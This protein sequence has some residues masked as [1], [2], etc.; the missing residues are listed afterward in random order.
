MWKCELGQF[1]EETFSLC[2]VGG[3]AR[4][5]WLTSIWGWT[6]SLFYGNT[7]H[8]KTHSG[9]KSNKCNQYDYTSSQVSHLRTHL[10]N[11]EWTKVEQMQPVWLCIHSSRQFEDTFEKTQLLQRKIYQ[12]DAFH[13]I[14]YILQGHPERMRKVN[15]TAGVLLFKNL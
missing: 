3:S 5:M 7:K 6:L 12:A 8:L 11:A 15:Y 9:E 2:D 4:A 1:K 14:Y 10:K 13:R